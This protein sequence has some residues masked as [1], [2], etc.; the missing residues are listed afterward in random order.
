[1]L[2]PDRLFDD[3]FDFGEPR[4]APRESILPLRIRTPSSSEE[5]E[6]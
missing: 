4:K 2:L 1:M 3:M 5:T 6:F